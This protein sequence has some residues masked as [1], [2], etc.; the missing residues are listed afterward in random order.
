MQHSLTSRR[1]RQLIVRAGWGAPVEFT[2]AKVVSNV[3][4]AEK[5]HRVVID[6]GDLAADYT[7]GGQFMQIKVSEQAAAEL[8]DPWRKPT[9]L[10]LIMQQAAVDSM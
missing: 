4:D 3:K 9:H 5:L 6:V 10:F 8:Q 2:A 7:K 1:T